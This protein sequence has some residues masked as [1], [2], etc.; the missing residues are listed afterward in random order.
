MGSHNRID[1][2]I[3]EM[4]QWYQDGMT[5]QEIGDRLGRDLRLVHKALKKAGV[6]MR[7]RGW[8]NQQGS[9]NVSWNGGRTTDKHGYVLIRKPE[10]PMANSAGYVREHRLV[11]EEIL[12][13]P[14]TQTEVVHHLN[15]EPGDNHPDNLMVYET[16]GRHLA[17]TL[18]GKCP[19]WTEEGRD[20][21][22]ES[23]RR[24][25]KPTGSRGPSE[26]GDGP[27]Q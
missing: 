19:Q 27:S 21:I 18:K 22:L 2:P 8:N 23:V 12:G 13:R 3:E 16:N 25:R 11:V 7:P 15:D 26:S 6:P 17:E 1:W 20:R 5:L 4:T 10:H 14:L 9:R 24:P